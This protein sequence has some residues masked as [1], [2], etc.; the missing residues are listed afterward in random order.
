VHQLQQQVVMHHQLVHPP[1]RTGF[2]LVLM[3]TV[4]VPALVLKLV[5]VPVLL[6]V[7]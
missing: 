4:L 7:L 5:P 6:L 1:C 2:G 3:M